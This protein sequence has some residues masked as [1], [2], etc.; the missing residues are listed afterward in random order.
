M[1]TPESHQDN[2]RTRQV[3]TQSIQLKSSQFKSAIIE[4][5]DDLSSF[6]QSGNSLRQRRLTLEHLRLINNGKILHVKAQNDLT[7]TLASHIVSSFPGIYYKN[8][9]STATLW[10][11]LNQVLDSA[12]SITY[13]PLYQSE[14]ELAVALQYLNFGGNK[15]LTYSLVSSLLSRFELFLG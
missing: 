15:T 11:F 1:N 3:K 12:S 6:F 9:L 7:V 5:F 4:I 13:L 10:E 8:G 2:T 14:A